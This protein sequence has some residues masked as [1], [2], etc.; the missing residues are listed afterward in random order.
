M[1]APSTARP[2]AVALSAA[3]RPGVAASST[4]VSRPAAEGRSKA[5]S[6]VVAL[7]VAARGSSRATA[8]GMTDVRCACCCIVMSAAAAPVSASLL[9]LLE[10]L[11]AGS[12]GA[13]GATGRTAGTDTGGREEDEA[14]FRRAEAR[15]VA[16]TTRL[17]LLGRPRRAEGAR[18]AGAA[19]ARERRRIVDIMVLV[20]K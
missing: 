20:T 6:R 7:V 8:C 9:P 11:A 16:T 10:G 13:T 4:A 15:G 1:A 19:A 5:S 3:S 14:G 2:A 18:A 17:P 12:M